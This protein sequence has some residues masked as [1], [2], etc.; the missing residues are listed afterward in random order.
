MA[1]VSERKKIKRKSLMAGAGSEST[2]E[3]KKKLRREPTEERVQIADL[4]RN[5][6][7]YLDRALEGETI[8]VVRGERPIAKLTP[9]Q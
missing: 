3:K 2:T 1:L 5:L 7:V 9:L 4:R 8:T 6:K